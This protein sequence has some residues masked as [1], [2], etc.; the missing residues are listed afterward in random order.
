TTLLLA[1]II[2][3]GIYL[4][5][6]RMLWVFTVIT[7]FFS[8]LLVYVKNKKRI[9]GTIAVIALLLCISVLVYKKDISKAKS[10]LRLSTINNRAFVIKNSLGLFAESPLLGVGYRESKLL[11]AG[12]IKGTKH[13]RASPVPHN[14]VVELLLVHGVLGAVPFILLIV[15]S[16]LQGFLLLKP[17]AKV[18]PQSAVVHQCIMLVFGSILLGAMATPVKLF[19][20]IWIFL[21]VLCGAN[22]NF[23]RQLKSGSTEPGA[24]A[25]KKEE[26][27]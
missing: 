21:A 11:L 19:P 25:L 3:I 15:A 18:D 16:F 8:Y 9:F 22:I 10:R 27:G 7:T 12:L 5:Q 2:F 14:I 13:H 20:L 24:T 4:A 26:H 1:G 6:T 23:K 17:L